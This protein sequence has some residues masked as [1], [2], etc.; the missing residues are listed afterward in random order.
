MLFTD[1]DLASIG[2]L[3]ASP[4]LPAGATA[5]QMAD[6]V[7]KYVT[8]NPEKRNFSASSMVSGALYTAWPPCNKQGK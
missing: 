2:Y 5:G 3:K 6:V 8:E 1:D 7:V 4:C